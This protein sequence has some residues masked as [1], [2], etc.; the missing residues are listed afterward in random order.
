MMARTE[1]NC[2]TPRTMREVVGTKPPCPVHP[3]PKGITYLPP[4]RDI[5]IS[6]EPIVDP[7][8]PS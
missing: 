7:G 5:R 2:P 6:T 8:G 1:C 4:I 3:E